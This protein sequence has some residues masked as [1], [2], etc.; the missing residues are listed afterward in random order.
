M[1]DIENRLNRI[2][3]KLD[4]MVETITTIARIEERMSQNKDEHERVWETL[5]NHTG[6]IETLERATDSNSFITRRHERVY[7]LIV[8]AAIGVIAYWMRT[9]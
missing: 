7:W 1:A 4:K 8:T 3:S 9:G 2:E 6:R 5:Q